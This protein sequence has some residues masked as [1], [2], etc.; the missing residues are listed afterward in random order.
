MF[1]E[2]V[3]FIYDNN[4]FYYIEGEKELQSFIE[5]AKKHRLSEELI[6]QG[7][8]LLQQLTALK[9]NEL[10]KHKSQI[11]RALRIELSDKYL[12]P[13]DRIKYSL[14]DDKQLREAIGV[15]TNESEYKKK[16]YSK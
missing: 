3:D 15:L 8:D 14:E 11:K 7:E 16:I 6:I 5:K 12:S 2:F 4:F 9:H 1:Q 10:I 13:T